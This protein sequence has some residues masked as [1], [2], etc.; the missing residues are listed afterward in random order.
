[1]RPPAVRC[2]VLAASATSSSLLRR[3][4]SI[5]LVLIPLGQ[6]SVQQVVEQGLRARRNAC[7]RWALAAA[8]GFLL[9]IPLQGLA[10]WRVYSTVTGSQ[11][12][13]ISQFSQK[14]EDLRQA[15]RSA[16]SH[17]ELQASVQKLFGPNAV[18][19]PA[20]LRTPMPDLRHMLLAR[21]E[22]ASRQLV[23]Q[24][25]A[26]AAIKPD[27]MLKENLRISIS[28]VAY[29]IGFAVLAVVLPRGADTGASPRRGVGRKPFRW[30][31][32]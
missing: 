4:R 9:L 12:Q 15:I 17:Q 13:Q 32:K 26:Q 21:A 27:Q 14:L 2:A 11:Q 28:A 8:I 23:Q 22:Q 7:R 1:M 30:L 29:V 19:S 24:V 20:E 3:N 10:G 5:Q 6:G 18:L 31:A 16:T 25:E